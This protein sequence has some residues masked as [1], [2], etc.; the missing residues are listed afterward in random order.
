MIFGLQV[1]RSSIG[2]SVKHSPLKVPFLI[3]HASTE[4]SNN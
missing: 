2:S 1:S 3:H 4:L